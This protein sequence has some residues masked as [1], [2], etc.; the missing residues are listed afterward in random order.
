MGNQIKR[1]GLGAMIIY[2]DTVKL[3]TAIAVL[4][5]HNREVARDYSDDQLSTILTLA[6]G[7]K[8]GKNH[9]RSQGNA[10]RIS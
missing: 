8:I 5:S 4:L 9:A 10:F 7:M 6:T 3:S 1:L 2:K